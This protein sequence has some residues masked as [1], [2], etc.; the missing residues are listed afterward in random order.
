M[1]GFFAQPRYVFPTLTKAG[2]ALW[3]KTLDNSLRFDT[4]D[5]AKFRLHVLD[6]MAKYGWKS[7][8]NAFGVKK[9][10]LYDWRKAFVTSQKRLVSL[11]PKSTRPHRV[12]QMQVNPKIL[13][14]IK[15]VRQ[16]YGKVGKK[17][18]K[19]LTDAYAQEQGLKCVGTTA[20]EKIVRRNHWYFEGKRTWKRK[21]ALKKKHRRYAPK[22]ANPGYIEMDSITI[23]ML[24]KRHC[25]ITAIDVVTKF[26]WCRKVTGLTAKNALVTFQEFVHHYP[27]A[28]HTIQTD[29]GSE[30][31]ADFHQ[32]LEN[33]HINH[34]F[35]YPRSPK[36]NGVIERFNRTIQEE[37]LNRCEEITYDPHQFS[38]KLS[39]YLNWYNNQRPHASL[40]YLSPVRYQLSHHSEM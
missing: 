31:L 11:V 15:A 29:N 26:A 5:V 24:S 13:S 19:L 21:Y 2:Y 36:I 16:Q 17:K 9:S 28:I 39:A 33:N 27:Y 22:E 6:H 25:F 20:I 30:F 3:M 12:R 7:A 4:S 35:I 18:L 14:F 10:T 38:V 23:V 8:V 34:H 40:G 32:F 1:E 37:F